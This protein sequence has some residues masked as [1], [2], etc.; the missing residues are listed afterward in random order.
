MSYRNQPP[1]IKPGPP[2]PQSL[3]CLSTRDDIAAAVEHARCKHPNFRRTWWG[4]FAVLFEEVAELVWAVVWERDPKR[5]RA[6]ALDCI[7]VLVRIIEHDGCVSKSTQN[8]TQ[9]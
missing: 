1:E 8:E 3:L 6:E 7:A 4:K 9:G 5:I 2:F